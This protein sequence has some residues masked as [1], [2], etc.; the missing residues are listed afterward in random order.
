MIQLSLLSGGDLP[1]YPGKMRCRPT[2]DMLVHLG[3]RAAMQGPASA[4][5]MPAYANDISHLY[6]YIVSDLDFECLIF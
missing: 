2:L 4:L 3:K 1:Y 6:T 5:I